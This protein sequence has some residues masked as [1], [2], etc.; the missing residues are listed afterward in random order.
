MSHPLDE[1]VKSLK[2][3]S[4]QNL[5]AYVGTL[6]EHA[7]YDGQDSLPDWPAQFI[8]LARMVVRLSI[9]DSEE[10]LDGYE[11]LDDDCE[12]ISRELDD[13]I[14]EAWVTPI[15]EL[16]KGA[17]TKVVPSE[18]LFSITLSVDHPAGGN[19]GWQATTFMKDLALVS[20]HS[21]F[22]PSHF[23]S[24]LGLVSRETL[25]SSSALLLREYVGQLDGDRFKLESFGLDELEFKGII[26]PE[27]YRLLLAVAG[28]GGDVFLTMT[29]NELARYRE[30]DMLV[31]YEE[32]LFR[33]IINC[34][35]Q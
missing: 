9:K 22:T 18:E 21:D 34:C 23:M 17:K 31:G 20:F 19:W 29:A 32:L 15:G 12:G 24:P 25:Y 16:T 14:R 6:S 13:D 11:L 27:L 30:P 8:R 10:C 28:R 2:P 4:H 35:W 3:I 5:K 7:G 33:N 1:W 26:V